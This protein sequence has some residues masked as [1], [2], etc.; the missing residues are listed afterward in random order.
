MSE[1]GGTSDEWRRTGQWPPTTWTTEAVLV[2]GQRV[3]ISIA[4][5]TP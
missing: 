5:A 1:D 2:A 4:E 3:G